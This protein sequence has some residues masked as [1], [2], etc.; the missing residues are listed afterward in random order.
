MADSEATQ[1][2]HAKGRVVRVIGPVVDVEFPPAEL[3]EINTALRVDLT[4]GDDT[5]TITCEVAQHIGDST[6]RTIALRPTDGLVRG[7]PVENTGS[8]ITVPV[9]E[10]VL[11]HVYNVIGEPLDAWRPPTRRRSQRSSRRRR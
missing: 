5:T 7:T 11:G 2:G 6:V 4:I 3:P 10:G 1:N 8:P 9:G